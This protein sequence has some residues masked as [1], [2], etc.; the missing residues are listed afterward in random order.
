MAA[1][2]PMVEPD[3]YGVRRKSQ[4]ELTVFLPQA[5]EEYGPISHYFIVVIPN[6]NASNINFP[7]QFY[8]PDLVANTKSGSGGGKRTMSKGKGDL[9]YIAAKFLQRSIPYTFVLGDGQ[10]Y[11]GFINYKLKSGVLYKI[12]VR[13][14]VDTPQKHLFTSSPFSPDLS[15]DMMAEP[16]GPLPERPQPGDHGNNGPEH[17]PNPE[18]N[19]IYVV[20]VVGP[21]LAALLFVFLVILICVLKKRRQNPKQP[22]EQGAVLTPL[23]SGFDMNNAAVGGGGAARGAFK[24]IPAPRGCSLSFSNIANLS[25]ASASIQKLLFVVSDERGKTHAGVNRTK[26]SPCGV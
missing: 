19:S 21:V 15:L 18:I 9:P 6:S 25:L 3:F 24:G 12:F 10:N 23:M 16:P 2:Q 4:G 1:P 13:A 17:R 5:S 26:P 22:L 8:T 7:D 14:Y 11:E 20:K